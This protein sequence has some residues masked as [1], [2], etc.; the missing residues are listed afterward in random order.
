[1]YSVRWKI[2]GRNNFMLEHFLIYNIYFC[3]S[4]TYENKLNNTMITILKKNDF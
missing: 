3:I 1:M 4:N 2:V